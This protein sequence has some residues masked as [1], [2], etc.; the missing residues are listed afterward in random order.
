MRG[1]SNAFLN[2]VAHGSSNLKW[3]PLQETPL[4]YSSCHVKGLPSLCSVTC[5]IAGAGAWSVI[6][7]RDAGCATANGRRGW[8]LHNLGVK[9][10][11]MIRGQRRDVV[12]PGTI[13]FPGAYMVI[14]GPIVRISVA[15]V[16]GRCRLVTAGALG[17][18]VK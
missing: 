9:V 6:T 13:I 15:V 3:S 1:R 2:V 17:V 7:T 12:A 5:R 16:L 10:S 14:V 18:D 8:S 4:S 11:E